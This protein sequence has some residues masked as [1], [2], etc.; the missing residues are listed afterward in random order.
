MAKRASSVYIAE[1]KSRYKDKVYTSYLLR[2]AYRE[3]GKVKQQTLGNLSALPPETIALLRGSLHGQH[4]VPADESSEIITTR[5][6]GHVAAVGAMCR[7]LGLE[8]MI[9][10]APSA[11]R[12][13][14]MAMIVAR[15]VEPFPKLSTT[16]WW[17]TTTLVT[18]PTVAA[19]DEDDLYD[20]MDWLVLRQSRIERRIARRHLHD[21]GLVLYDLSSSYVEGSH[22]PLARRGYN[23][24]GKQGKAQVNY[25]L[26]LDP[27]GRPVAVQVYEGN[28]ADPQTVPDQ[29][30]KI[31]AD[32]HLQHVVLV[33]DRG[34]LTSARIREIRSDGGLDWISALRA[35][36]I[37]A[38]AAAG[39]VSRS[40]FD[41]QDLVE[42]SSPDFPG[43]RLVLCRNPLLA[44]ERDRTRCALLAATEERLARL[45]RRVDAGRLKDEAKIGAALQRAV[46]RHKVAKHFICE[47]GPG[48]L[49]YSRDLARITAEAALDGIYV[50]RTNVPAAE[51]SAER[52]VLSYKSLARAEQAFRTLKSIDLRVR[53]IH[54]RLERRVRAHIFLCMLAYYVEWHLRQAWA[55]YL[56]EDELPGR[57]A[58]D[59]VVQAAL[60]SPQALHKARTKRTPAGD[61]V[62]SFPALL[63]SLSTV[64]RNELRVPAHP[65]LGTFHLITVPDPIQADLF[66]RV[67]LEVT[68][69]RRQRNRA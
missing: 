37:Q 36:D 39:A 5:H 19:A 20:A 54:H 35:K 22:C 59:S 25:G 41:E 16:A 43:E 63:A 34:M 44:E 47:V 28:T 68:A 3:D 12:D 9:D 4:Y 51:L 69:E 49:S 52:V 65:E 29:V 21:G 38:L 60:R 61:P 24:D 27:D 50:V 17:Q 6:H 10:P 57:H 48:H 30:R 42:I 58:H 18:D 46:A 23:R 62:R 33:G 55:P 26:L 45:K 66:A 14:V 15:V 32:F 13:L 8:A 2:R 67:G 1:I 40:L 7:R 56:F 11:Q 64:A 53:P 31:Q